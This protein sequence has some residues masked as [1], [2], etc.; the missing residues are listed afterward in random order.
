M[1]KA[2]YCVIT[3]IDFRLQETYS[4]FL[5]THNMLGTSDIVSLAGCSR[6]L[7]KPLADF[8]KDAFLRQVDLSV[9]L[10]DP[11]TIVLLDHQDCGGYAQDLT[12]ASGLSVEE[13]IKAHTKWGNRAKE[14]LEG[15]YPG[16]NVR[17][18]F[19]R[20]SGEVSELSS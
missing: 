4:G 2:K 17:V 20:L 10:H 16:K 8:H 14:I 11:D 18:Y 19:A 3:C 1:H 13:D 9:K 6:D 15:K 12:I 5:K 7:V